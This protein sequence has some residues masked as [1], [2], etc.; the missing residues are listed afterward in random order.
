MS[1][2]TRNA[3]S[4][5]QESLFGTL[6]VRY[7]FVLE[8]QVKEA[9]DIQKQLKQSGQNV[10]RMGE[11]LAQ[12]GYITIDQVQAVLKG[13]L[14]SSPRRFGEIAVSTHLCTHA[15][16]EAALQVQAQIKACGSYQRIGEILVARGALR[17][18]QV[19]SVLKDQGKAIL[20]CPGCQAKLNVSGVAPGSSVS[21]P[22]CKTVFTP[23]SG[24]E[25]VLL[26]QDEMDANVRADMTVTMPA[27]GQ[28][29]ATK[30]ATGMV[31]PYQLG[32]KLGND[33]S[34]VLY[35]AFDPQHGV[36]VALRILNPATANTRQ[37][38]DRWISAGEAASELTHPNLQR[39]L[40]IKSDSG[41]VYLVMEYVEGESLRKSITRRQKFPV[42]EAVDVLI[43]MAEALAYGHAHGFLH[44]DLRPA[45]VLIGFDGI[46]RISGLGT[47]KNVSQNIRQV[48]GQV[49]DETLPLYTPP[50]LFI[51]EEN[52]EERSD[53]YS[54]GAIGYQ[55]MS[56]RPPHEGNNVL[57]VGLRMASEAIKPPR[58]FEPKIPP[59]V[60]RLLCRC[61]LPEPD[62][63]YDNMEALLDDLR[64]SRQALLSDLGDLPEIGAAPRTSGVRPGVGA[65]PRRNLK[66]EAQR[67][68]LRT[69]V[70]RG[71]HGSTTGRYG[72][73]TGKQRPVRPGSRSN[74]QMRAV[75]TPVNMP[76]PIAPVSSS[77]GLPMVQVNRPVRK[78]AD[79][80]EETVDLL[81][82]IDP[83]AVETTAHHGEAPPSE[84]VEPER[85]DKEFT[86]AE[87]R[88]KK[89]EGPPLDPGV[90]AKWVLVGTF[91]A[92]LL[93]VGLIVL[94]GQNNNTN[95]PAV[96][97]TVNTDKPKDPTPTVVV[98]SN[99]AAA[100]EWRQ[101]QD[102]IK[103]NP[104]DYQG[105]VQ[106]LGTFKLKFVDSPTPAEQAKDAVDQLKQYSSQGANASLGELKSAI[107]KNVEA[108]KFG[109]AE[110]SIEHWRDQ[111]K[112]DAA[113]A[114]TAKSLV[115]ELAAKQKQ[116]AESH[117]AGAMAARKE[118]K[119]EQ[120]YSLYKRV[121]ENYATQYAD[122]ARK[123]KID[124]MSDADASRGGEEKEAALKK[125]AE[126]QAARDAAAPARMQ[127]LVSDLDSALKTFD[128]DQGKRLLD[129]AYELL[130]GTPQGADFVELKGDYTKIL[131]L[132]DRM[133]KS[134]GKLSDPKVTYRNQQ[135]VMVG[136]AEK[137]PIIEVGT[138]KV[139]ISWSEISA[140]DLDAI[141]KRACNPDNG[142]EML[143][144]GM[145]RYHLGDY[146][147]SKKALSEAQRL[148]AVTTR[149]M[150][151]VDAKLKELAAKTPEPEK[152]PEKTPEV[153]KTPEKVAVP[154]PDDEVVK[155][156]AAK[157]LEINR[158]QWVVS[159]NIFRG[160]PD[161]G[162]N[163][164]KLM[165]LKT[166]IKKNFSKV[167][168]E[169][170]GVGGE[171]AGF[172]FG[173]GRRYVIKPDGGW[174]KVTVE[175]NN[176]GR[177]QLTIDGKPI[178]S[179]DKPEAG[180][181]PDNLV[182]D[183]V[184][185][186]R[187]QGPKGEFRNLTIDN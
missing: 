98:A 140:D 5:I 7:N 153:V 49:G 74:A 34:G 116:M 43:Q 14:S 90:S 1:L 177:P 73:V 8:H 163:D 117:M 77:S 111:W 39:I 18:H 134:V 185:Y 59:Y 138:G 169:V 137:G 123:A 171:M 100:S 76:S 145:L 6:A 32:E 151:R 57:Q 141:A 10:P 30:P 174:Q 20:S 37:A 113:T 36:T 75:Q 129:N 52:A 87:R 127:A 85:L 23:P 135:Y 56:G 97:P 182:L 160:T 12:R 22:R 82:D 132:R 86:A 3:S 11:I 133:V 67:K 109:E 72:A 25:S 65:A 124:A 159:G 128:L 173:K 48:A 83:L 147:D 143:D 54:L 80:A 78:N 58:D 186:L 119:W 64:K 92:I 136:A 156:M 139:P 53:I 40:S 104:Q 107:A 175:R 144:L 142:N 165:S 19:H 17:P 27:V 66:A 168:V 91:G 187:F 29:L 106:R 181:N 21:C 150:T 164:T 13:Q 126:A 179:L 184:L 35:K 121:Y 79:G 68:K 161:P 84:P 125:A 99:P 131:G 46:V 28:N 93:V 148:G 130:S 108:E 122:A 61:L 94:L 115:D 112:G 172:S 16:V 183:G 89:K 157:G 60:N 41:R 166:N 33:S 176:G 81:G 2:E 69:H 50:E 45:H 26:D 110:K 62:D 101:I 47:P 155:A 4:P 170:R 42:L 71:G 149:Y 154:A 158:G 9:L 114:A 152:T 38:I 105:I 70:T 178:E 180:V 31:G 88:K 63:R 118:K 95:H 120:A 167:S 24:T 103:A 102:H 15:D 96:P 146:R 51:D 162:D 44:G 55:M